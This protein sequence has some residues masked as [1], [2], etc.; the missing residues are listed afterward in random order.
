MDSRARRRVAPN[1]YVQVWEPTHP[2]A[3]SDGY[4]AEHRK[5]VWDAGITFPPEWHVHH[6][7]GAK[8]DNRLEN[9]EV[10]DPS[11]HHR[12]HV[13]AAGV[14]TN[15]HGTFPVHRDRLAKV[16]AE[17]LERKAAMDRT[18][19]ECGAPIAVERPTTAI[20]CSARCRSRR[21]AERARHARHG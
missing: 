5:V 14:V 21:F 2:L 15:Q 20:Y 19:P 13:A 3:M 7:N 6:I 18:C 4:V 11:A 17:R 12:E 9:L 8:D 16:K 1:G 10:V